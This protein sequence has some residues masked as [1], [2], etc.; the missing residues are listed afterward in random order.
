MAKSGAPS[1]ATVQAWV[2]MVDG[3][4]ALFGYPAWDELSPHA[5]RKIDGKAPLPLFASRQAI[6]LEMKILLMDANDATIEGAR[7]RFRVWVDR[8]MDD[9]TLTFEA[10]DRDGWHCISRIDVAPPGSHPNKH[11]RRLSLEPMVEGSHIHRCKE[12]ARLG[13]IAFTAQENLPAAV[14]LEAEPQ[15]FRDIC[16]VAEIEWNIDGL[17]NLEPPFWVHGRGLV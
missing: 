5:P 8:P 9:I 16:R 14:A 10:L 11:W 17:S 6:Q 13:G 7:L 15:S 12:N 1:D 4:K 3:K 2:G